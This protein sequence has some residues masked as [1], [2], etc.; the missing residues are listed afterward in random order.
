MAEV[1]PSSNNR[2]TEH[3]RQWT[4]DEERGTIWDRLERFRWENRKENVEEM[5][6]YRER[7][8]YEVINWCRKT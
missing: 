7:L 1:G 6:N 3:W 4:V 2:K 8:K 5:F